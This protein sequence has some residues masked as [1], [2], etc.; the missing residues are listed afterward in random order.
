MPTKGFADPNTLSFGIFSREGKRNAPALANLRYESKFFW[1]GRAQSLEDQIEKPIAHPDE[2]GLMPDQVEARLKNSTKY[3]PLFKQ[4]F[5]K[6]PI[7]NQLAVKAISQYVRTL[8]SFGS[9]Y[10]KYLM[11]ELELA[12]EEKRGMKLFFTHPDPSANIRGGNCGD[13][14]QPILLAGSPIGFNGFK[15]NGLFSD[16]DM[17]K[18]LGPI[19]GKP[20]DNG[21]FK[22]PSLRNIAITQPYMH[23]GEFFSLRQV[24]EHYNSP[25]LFAA[26]GVDTLILAGTNERRGTSLM[27]N[28]DEIDDI[29]A[30][31]KTLTD[32]SFARK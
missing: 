11:G 7:T 30:F 3:P 26:K 1:D 2:M 22:V 24:V 10:D 31:L 9:R 6:A 4:A 17:D 8:T 25:D 20:S 13:C 29:L 27:L 32:T 18:G 21:K 28:D 5:G 19:T 15:N 14:H 16:R 12:P 23:D